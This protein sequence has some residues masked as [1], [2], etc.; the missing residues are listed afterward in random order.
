MGPWPPWTSLKSAT[1]N[2]HISNLMDVAKLKCKCGQICV[3][4]RY[5]MSAKN[6]WSAQ[7]I[8]KNIIYFCRLLHQKASLCF[9]HF[10]C[11]IQLFE[12][13]DD[14][15]ENSIVTFRV[16]RDLASGLINNKKEAYK[17]R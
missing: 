12:V 8:F 9:N 17:F 6:L 14:V 1:G 3:L 5:C 10:F 4:S 16:P 11:F 13:D 15:G 2:N 7:V